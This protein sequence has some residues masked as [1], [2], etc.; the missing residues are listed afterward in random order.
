MEH[1]KALENEGAILLAQSDGCS[2]W[3]FR[4]LSPGEG[5]MTAYGGISRCDAQLQ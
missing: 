5:T 2:V 3:Q 1:T 4:N